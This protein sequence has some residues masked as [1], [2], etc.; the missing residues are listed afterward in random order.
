[1]QALKDSMDM[2][3]DM[4]EAEELEAELEETK[5]ELSDAKDRLRELEQEPEDPKSLSTDGKAWETTESTLEYD[6]NRQTF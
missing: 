4:E 6:S 5:S 1:M 3:Y 2:A